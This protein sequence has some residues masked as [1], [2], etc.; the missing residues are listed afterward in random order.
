MHTLAVQEQ[1]CQRLVHQRTA[2]AV[3]RLQADDL[4]RAH[5]PRVHRRAPLLADVDE[6]RRRRRVR[7]LPLGVRLDEQLDDRPLLFH[8]QQLRVEFE[9]EERREQLALAGDLHL[10]GG[11]RQIAALGA[12]EI[13]DAQ[14][15]SRRRRVRRA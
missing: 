8:R 14:C 7:V 9:P 5:E 4:V 15:G 13:A 3:G 6:E 1:Q 10:P 2:F 12:D 11:T